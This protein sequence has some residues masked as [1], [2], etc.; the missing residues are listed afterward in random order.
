MAKW[1]GRCE[2]NQ[3]TCRDRWSIPLGRI[4]SN[5]RISV[6]DRCNIRCFYCMPNEN[7]QFKPREEILTFEEITRLVRVMVQLGVNRLRITGGE[8]LVRTGLPKLVRML[9]GIPDLEDIAMT[10]NGI[11]LAGHAQSSEGGG[12]TPGEHQPGRPE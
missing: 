12:S 3:T 5:L 4:H 7:V 9:S 8:P 2:Q 6:T 10:T 11:L 1:C